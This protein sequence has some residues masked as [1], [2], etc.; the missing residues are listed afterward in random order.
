MDPIPT[1][2]PP[3]GRRARFVTFA[4]LVGL[5]TALALATAGPLLLGEGME[6]LRRVSSS[7]SGTFFVWVIV[8]LAAILGLAVPLA[9]AGVV[10]G[11][12][13]GRARLGKRDQDP[14]LKEPTR[15]ANALGLPYA[16]LG[17]VHGHR[18][19]TYRD[20]VVVQTETGDP[21]RFDRAAL[22]GLAREDGA[23]AEAARTLRG[24]GVRS[25][26][27]GDGDVVVDG[28]DD[29]ALGP[30]VRAALDLAASQ[31]RLVRVA[32][33]LGAAA[34]VGKGCPYC[35]EE[36]QSVHEAPLV[37]CPACDVQQHAECWR[38]HGGCAVWRCRR[39][40]PPAVEARRAEQA[41]P[42]APA[43]PGEGAGAGEPPRIRVS[44]RS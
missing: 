44:V 18:V 36:L 14:A 2:E 7:F 30:V 33:R 34:E 9:L 28:L 32:P 12:L 20:R 5:L 24:H 29:G 3:G 39:A 8:T 26:S 43:E 21:V 22:R 16:V 35:H 6:A 4:A 41:E 37:R 25:V 31:R 38:D 27:L 17:T 15:L 10:V 19:R 40:P 23:A 1:R 11:W 42:P 13:V